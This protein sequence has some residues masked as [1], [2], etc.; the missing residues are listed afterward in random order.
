MDIE[1]YDVWQSGAFLPPR[2][3]DNPRWQAI[4]RWSPYAALAR[5]LSTAL[6]LQTLRFRIAESHGPRS[7]WHKFAMSRA[8]GIPL[9]VGLDNGLALSRVSRLSFSATR[10]SRLTKLEL[11]GFEDIELLLTLAPNLENLSVNLSG[12]F[13]QS[14]C[15]HFLDGL[16][17]VPKLRQLAF[18]PDALHIVGPDADVIRGQSGS[19]LNIITLIGRSLPALEVLDLRG[20]WH[21][22][23]VNYQHSL[24]YLSHEVSYLLP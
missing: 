17:R 5:L 10:L 11:D 21:G 2:Q 6:G 20:Y 23:N 1:F 14:A 8:I 3:R 13:P 7:A 18:S 4:A 15:V 19:I 9:G 22:D 12:G 16:G 24:E